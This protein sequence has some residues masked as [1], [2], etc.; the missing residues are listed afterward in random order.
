MKQCAHRAGDRA[1]HHGGD[2]HKVKAPLMVVPHGM[3]YNK[4]FDSEGR[5]GCSACRR[6][7]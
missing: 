3:G 6:T 1:Q 5:G 7:G 4:Y 2:L